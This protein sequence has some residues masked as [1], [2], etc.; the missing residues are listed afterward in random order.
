MNY[1]S[2]QLPVDPPLAT[3]QLSSPSAVLCEGWVLKKRR[4]KMQGMFFSVTLL[5]SSIRFSQVLPDAT[6]CSS[7]MGCCSTPLNRLG[8]F[9][10]NYPSSMLLYPRLSDGGIYT[11]IRT[12][13][14]STSNASAPLTLICGWQHS[15]QHLGPPHLV[16]GSLS[17]FAERSFL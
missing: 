13:G 8:Q 9:G 3:K 12:L 10:T 5:V 1:A 11:L 4:K 17:H 16:I 14:L 7:T 6:L 15:G 2:S